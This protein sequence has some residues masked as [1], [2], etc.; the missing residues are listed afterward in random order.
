MVSARMP[1]DRC[2]ATEWGALELPGRGSATT[3]PKSGKGRLFSGHVY[4]KSVAVK[5]PF[6]QRNF[7]LLGD[8]VILL[9]GIARGSGQVKV[10]PER[11]LLLLKIKIQNNEREP[12]APDSCDEVFIG[13]DASTCEEFSREGVRKGRVQSCLYQIAGTEA[14]SPSMGRKAAPV[15]SLDGIVLS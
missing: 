13:D 1:G 8:L 14:E 15:K 2:N 12:F 5:E 3:R 11:I 6:W 10:Q 7:E 4:V 9:D